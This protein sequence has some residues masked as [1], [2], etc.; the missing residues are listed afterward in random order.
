M[1]GSLSE[2]SIA[3]GRGA[4]RIRLI[5]ANAPN[6]FGLSQ[7][8]CSDS[9]NSASVHLRSRGPLG[10]PTLQRTASRGVRIRRR[11]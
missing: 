6:V 10:I 7:E 11:M 2:I 4:I 8:R 1:R 3:S 5:A 9:W